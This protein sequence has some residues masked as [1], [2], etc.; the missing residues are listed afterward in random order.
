VLEA[1][2][3]AAILVV[4]VLGSIGFIGNGIY[5]QRHGHDHPLLRRIRNWAL[6]VVWPLI[7]A[8]AIV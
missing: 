5:T 3:T 8:R 7:L 2:L 6:L 1:A 4:F